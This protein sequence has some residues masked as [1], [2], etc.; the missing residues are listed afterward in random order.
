MYEWSVVSGK[1]YV[2]YPVFQRILYI[3]FQKYA[4]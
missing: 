3:E 4:A 1:W 2:A